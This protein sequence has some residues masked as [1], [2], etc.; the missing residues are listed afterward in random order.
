M[1][2]YLVHVFFVFVS[3]S[4]G[5]LVGLITKA[6]SHFKLGNWMVSI[7]SEWIKELRKKQS[8]YFD[9][10]NITST[11]AWKEQCMQKPHALSYCFIVSTNIFKLYNSLIMYRRK[12]PNSDQLKTVQFWSNTLVYSNLHWSMFFDIE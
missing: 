11:H 4:S 2:C 7:M 1:H 10:C 8:L 6:L 3:F 12:F 9:M 5:A